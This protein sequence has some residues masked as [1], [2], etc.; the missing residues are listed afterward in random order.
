MDYEAA[1]ERWKGR[2]ALARV[3]RVAILVI[4]IAASIA[5][6]YLASRHVPPSSLGLNRWVWWAGVISPM[7]GALPP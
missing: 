1:G 7:T 6:S 3:L 4:P 2:P 5:T